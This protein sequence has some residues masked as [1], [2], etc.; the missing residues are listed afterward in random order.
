MPAADPMAL[1]VLA[2][3]AVR[4]NAALMGEFLTNLSQSKH[5]AISALLRGGG[6]LGVETLVRANSFRVLLVGIE[7]EGQRRVLA[8]VAA[9]PN[10]SPAGRVN[11]EAEGW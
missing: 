9:P 1:S 11:D 5:D 2:L 6:S 7:Q 4:V 3:E 8:E 10:P